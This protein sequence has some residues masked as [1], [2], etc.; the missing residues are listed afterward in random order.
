[1]INNITVPEYKEILPMICLDDSHHLNGN[2]VDDATLEVM[3]RIE[4]EMQR[5]KVMGSD[6]RRTLWLEIH[7]P[8]RGYQ[9]EEDRR[10]RNGNIWYWI[11]TANYEGFHY[12]IFCDGCFR[13]IDLRSHTHV[14]GERD[15]EHHTYADVCKPLLRLER[16][17]KD[18]VDA[19]CE[20]PAAYNEYVE[21]NLL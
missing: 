10:D 12:L 17:V 16:Y 4:K 7:L 11:T 18:I 13:I 14:H 1:M 3:L 8:G 9:W 6:E 21:Q 5:L 15:S 2:V 20:T 19:I